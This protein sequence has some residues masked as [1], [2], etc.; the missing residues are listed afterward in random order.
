MLL[1]AFTFFAHPTIEAQRS[2]SSD[3]Y[4]RSTEQGRMPP[5]TGQGESIDS[6]P[7]CTL[8]CDVS[9]TSQNFEA[10]AFLAHP[11]IKAR[12]RSNPSERSTELEGYMPPFTG[13]GQS[14]Y[15]PLFGAF[16]HTSFSCH[17][18]PPSSHTQQLEHGV[19]TH[20]SSIF[21][22]VNHIL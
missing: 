8:C 10:S 4:T 19:L 12:Q 17:K 7:L 22:Q 15:N 1:E 21:I 3:S 6:S 16:Y 9:F 5:F 14:A 20:L 2:N 13:N 11:T 18:H